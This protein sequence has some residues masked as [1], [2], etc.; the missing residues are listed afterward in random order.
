MTTPTQPSKTSED[1]CD[2][3]GD[4]KRNQRSPN[5]S[6]AAFYRSH[7]QAGNAI[8]NNLVL[9]LTPGFLEQQQ[10]RSFKN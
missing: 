9:G 6:P 4:T 10:P 5:T 8:S 7:E 3:L 2:D 1:Q